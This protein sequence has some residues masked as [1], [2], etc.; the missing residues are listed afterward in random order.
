M[1]G[2]GTT[3]WGV[4]A[5]KAREVSPGEVRPGQVLR[6][7]RRRVGASLHSRQMGQLRGS[8]STNLEQGGESVARASGDAGEGRGIIASA[9]S[10]SWSGGNGGCPGPNADVAAIVGAERPSCSISEVCVRVG[11]GQVRGK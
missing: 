9:M 7:K 10:K 11:T 1:H 4:R 3:A 2:Y 8:S 6:A 5:V